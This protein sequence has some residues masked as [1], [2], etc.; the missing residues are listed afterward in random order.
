[1]TITVNVYDAKTQLSSLLARVEAGEEVVIARNGRP[2]ARLTAVSAHRPDRV[3]GVWRGL[4]SVGA[5]FDDFTPA[6]E[7][8]WYGGSPA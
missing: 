3:P 1:M 6:D 5:D 7:A 8:D 2:I 4:V